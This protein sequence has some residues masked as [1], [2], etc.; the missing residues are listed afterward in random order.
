[1]K[2]N[3]KKKFDLKNKLAFVAGGSGYIGKEIVNGLI[4]MNCKV[5]VLDIYNFR[6]NKI[7][8]EHVDLSKT[9]YLEKKLKKYLRNMVHLTFL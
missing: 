1:M 7:I 5:V 9:I 4:S 2:I 3:Y 6:N 8:F